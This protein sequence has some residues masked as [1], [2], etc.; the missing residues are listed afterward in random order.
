M[1]TLHAKLGPEGAQ[2]HAIV[3]VPSCSPLGQNF[4]APNWLFSIPWP[5]G[6]ISHTGGG[7]LGKGQVIKRERKVYMCVCVCVCVRACACVGAIT[8]HH[9]HTSICPL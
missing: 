8:Y 7:G 5:G 3:L 6:Y 2:D 1:H 4:Y 9:A